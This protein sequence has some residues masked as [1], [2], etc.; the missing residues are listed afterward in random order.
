[1]QTRELLDGARLTK[2][3]LDALAERRSRYLSLGD[4]RG[5]SS[6]RALERL[7]RDIDRRIEALADQVLQIEARIDALEDERQRDVLR[8]RYL[9]GWRLKDI[10][11]RMNYSTDWVRHLHAR[12][13]EALKKVKE[14]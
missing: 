7:E 5:R 2:L 9:N 1:M 11:Q 13:L 10:A 8:Y 4:R 6:G 3:R 14:E 12:G